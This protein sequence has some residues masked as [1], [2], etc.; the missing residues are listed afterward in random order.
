[1]VPAV[2]KMLADLIGPCRIE[3]SDRLP[4][5]AEWT[6]DIICEQNQMEVASISQRKDYAGA[7]V[8]EVVI[9]TDRLVFNFDEKGG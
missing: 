7:K 3:K 6:Q 9:G 8:L 2:R 1:M 4:D 5:Y